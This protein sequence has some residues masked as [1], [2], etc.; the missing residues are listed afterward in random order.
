MS[1][2]KEG[3]FSLDIYQLLLEAS[4]RRRREEKARLLKSIGVKEYFEDGGIKIDKHTCKGVECGLC[5]KVCPT[6]AL[7]WSRGVVNIAEELCIYCSSCV[8]NC[9]IDN[10]IQVSRSRPNGEVEKF[11]TPQQAFMLL[12]NINSRKR[13]KVVEARF[14]PKKP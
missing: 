6:K 2:I 11:S 8:L 12:Y 10:C 3:G 9:I 7:Y 14:P 4:K 5:V 1:K 13:F